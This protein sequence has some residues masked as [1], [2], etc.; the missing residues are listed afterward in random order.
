MVDLPNS[1]IGT[2]DVQPIALWVRRQEESAFPCANQ[3]PYPAHTL[4]CPETRGRRTKLVTTTTFTPPIEVAPAAINAVV[5]MHAGHI[6]LLLSLRPLDVSCGC[7]DEDFHDRALYMVGEFFCSFEL[8]KI[9][10]AN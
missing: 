3:Y 7:I 10:G 2:A 6:G 4:L 1:K 5:V 9:V 8:S